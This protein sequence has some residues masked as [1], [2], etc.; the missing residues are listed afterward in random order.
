MTC[1]QTAKPGYIYSKATL[2]NAGK[3]VIRCSN[4]RGTCFGQI[5]AEVAHTRVACNCNWQ[6]YISQRF[7]TIMPPEGSQMD[8]E[9]VNLRIKKG[10]G[11]TKVAKHIKGKDGQII[12]GEFMWG[13]SNPK[14]TCEFGDPPEYDPKTGPVYKYWPAQKA[15][16]NEHTTKDQ[17]YKAMFTPYFST[18]QEVPI[19]TWN[20]GDAHPSFPYQWLEGEENP[21]CGLMFDPILMDS[22]LSDGRPRLLRG[23]G[24]YGTVPLKAVY[25]CEDDP[26]HTLLENLRNGKDAIKLAAAATSNPLAPKSASRT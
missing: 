11:T 16:L 23:N 15:E 14:N 13:N 3:L 2:R 26:L 22:D 7:L 24:P 8:V 17:L 21:H 12:I 20:I 4:P 10:Y 5:P 9:L 6:F 18:Y 19:G 1:N 25:W